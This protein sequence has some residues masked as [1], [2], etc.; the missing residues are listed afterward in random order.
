MKLSNLFAA[1]F[2]LLVS[3]FTSAGIVKARTI[4]SSMYFDGN[5]NGEKIYGVLNDWDGRACTIIDRKVTIGIV[6]K[7]NVMR[8]SRNR[9][10]TVTNTFSLN[11]AGGS[12]IPTSWRNKPQFDDCQKQMLRAECFLPSGVKYYS[13][14]NETF[15]NITQN[16]IPVFVLGASTNSYN[17]DNEVDSQDWAYF[18][19][20]KQSNSTDFIRHPAKVRDRCK[21]DR[22][23][24]N[25][26]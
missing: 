1:G 14:D 13:P 6:G 12:Q 2:L 10:L 4:N 19:L 24:T 20:N 7:N 16:R 5:Y 17:R 8:L 15:R 25:R 26:M 9:E 22:N 21:I 3:L 23:S 18:S 11:P